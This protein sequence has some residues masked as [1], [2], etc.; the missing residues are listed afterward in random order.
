MS[1]STE[2]QIFQDIVNYRNVNPQINFF[3]ENLKAS[4]G[5][6]TAYA[7]IKV[8][9]DI[10][11]TDASDESESVQ[12][13]DKSSEKEWLHW[14]ELLLNIY[15]VKWRL[16]SIKPEENIKNPL[17]TTFSRTFEHHSLYPEYWFEVL[18]GKKSTKELCDSP[19]ELLPAF[20]R[21]MLDSNGGGCWHAVDF[22]IDKYIFRC[23][24]EP[25]PKTAE[26]FETVCGKI[27]SIV[28]AAHRIVSGRLGLYISEAGKIDLPYAGLKSEDPSILKYHHFDRFSRLSFCRRHEK[29]KDADTR[30]PHPEFASRWNV[31]ATMTEFSLHNKGARATKTT[32]SR[33]AIG[34]L[35]KCLNKLLVENALQGNE[36]VTA[37][38]EAGIK[39][40]DDENFA[41]MTTEEVLEQMQCPL[42]PISADYYLKKYN[43]RSA[44]AFWNLAD[45][46]FNPFIAEFNHRYYAFMNSAGEKHKSLL[47]INNNDSKILLECMIW[48]QMDELRG[49]LNGIRLRE[50]LKELLIAG[51]IEFHS[52]Q[53]WKILNKSYKRGEAFQFFSPQKG[54]QTALPIPYHWLCADTSGKDIPGMLDVW[55]RNCLSE[56]TRDKNGEIVLNFSRIDFNKIMEASDKTWQIYFDDKY[57]SSV[58]SRYIISIL[59]A[60]NY[61]EQDEERYKG[62]KLISGA[63][64]EEFLRFL[65]DELHSLTGGAAVDLEKEKAAFTQKQIWCFADFSPTWARPVLIIDILARLVVQIAK[66]PV[67]EAVWENTEERVRFVYHMLSATHSTLHPYPWHLNLKGDAIFR[68]SRGA[69][70]RDHIT[71]LV[72][73]ELENQAEQ[74]CF[75][76]SVGKYLAAEENPECI[77]RAIIDNPSLS[78]FAADQLEHLKNY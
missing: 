64:R 28:M 26:D 4:T 67:L 73:F 70:Q 57:E 35:L 49:R 37:M 59:E 58:K 42:S 56:M 72:N 60:K 40:L 43:I 46:A 61:L 48:N 2:N 53:L 27:A 34:T 68:I 44:E 36:R 10:L 38:L 76:M 19:G 78:A 50:A 63:A 52:A 17:F 14:L 65:S 12:I 3:F 22:N 75:L 30:N 15:I 7:V 29:D 66:N 41:K 33:V 5:N 69:D 13:V 6:D 77:L 20:N 18:V 32:C 45:K 9:N 74:L 8:V 31:I 16:A 51:E 1:V 11:M 24:L 25:T 54:R 39:L 21:Y 55:A 23:I 71:R 62:V 47:P